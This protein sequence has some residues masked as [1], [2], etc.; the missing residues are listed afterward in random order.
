MSGEVPQD[1]DSGS[2]TEP[3]A[4]ERFQSAAAE[5]MESARGVPEERS[6]WQGGYSPRAMYGT[7]IVSGVVTIV[8]LVLV[9]LFGG[10][11]PYAW[12]A[13]GSA[14]LLWWCIAIAVYLYRRFS[15]HYELT[16]QRFVH[17]MG[18]LTRRTDRIEVIDIDDVSYTQGIIQ[19]MLGVGTITITGSDRSH[20][21][22]ALRGID[23]V[24][25]IAS[26]I[27]DV[28]RE[29]RRRRSLHIESI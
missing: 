16:T 26:L 24:P 1:A 8:A 2:P 7:W 28:R 12:P 27:D 19:R 6:L 5:R 4:Q 25:E 22:L 10:N 20:P 29:E 13:V 9:A 18:L 23:R 15:M 11:Q 21:E 17:Q 3:T 14:I